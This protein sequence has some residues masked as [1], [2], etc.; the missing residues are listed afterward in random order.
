MRVTHELNLGYT[1]PK[2]VWALILIFQVFIYNEVMASHPS[3]KC[4]LFSYNN[5]GQA[6]RLNNI[7]NEMHISCGND[8]PAQHLCRFHLLGCLRLL[9]IAAG[10]CVRGYCTIYPSHH[11][12]S[13]DMVHLLEYVSRTLQDDVNAINIRDA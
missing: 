4:R 6:N 12:E 1:C 5:Q 11:Q 10:E 9:V 8:V 2:C 13:H 7:E 3:Q